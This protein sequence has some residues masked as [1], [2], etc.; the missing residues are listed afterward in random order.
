MAGEPIE[1]TDGPVGNAVGGLALER[2]HYDC[3]CKLNE[4]RV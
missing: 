2:R 1:G 4:K 3:I